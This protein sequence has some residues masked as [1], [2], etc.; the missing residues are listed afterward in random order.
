MLSQGVRG[1]AWVSSMNTRFTTCT[2]LLDETHVSYVAHSLRGRFGGVH[3]TPL[4]SRTLLQ[5]PYSAL[6][7]LTHGLGPF[8]NV[9]PFPLFFSF[10]V[11]YLFCFFLFFEISEVNKW[12]FCI[13]WCVFPIKKNPDF[14]DK[15][16]A[17]F[18]PPP[19][20]L[21]ES[22]KKRRENWREKRKKSGNVENGA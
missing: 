3:K 17:C 7:Q 2:N 19:P 13:Q 5:V 20:T 18:R 12:E 10:P 15:I 4:F 9:P 22:K 8:L 6:F 16:T 11:D 14:P 21:K 1:V